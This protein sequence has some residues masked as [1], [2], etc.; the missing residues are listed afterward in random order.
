MVEAWHPLALQLPLVRVLV[1]LAV[2]GHLL[3][4]T[5]AGKE[6]AELLQKLPLLAVTSFTMAPLLPVMV[7]VAPD[8]AVFPSAP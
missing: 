7:T 1:I 4:S 2:S 3:T 8:T 5:L 6:T